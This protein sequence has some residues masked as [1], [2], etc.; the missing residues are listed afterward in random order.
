M[1]RAEVKGRVINDVVEIP[2]SA[3]R[4]DHT[5]L[6]LTDDEVLKILPVELA[7]TMKTKVLV[8]SGLADGM[9]V[10]VSPIEMPVDGM[11]L[12]VEEEQ[13]EDGAKTP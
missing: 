7:R 1:V 6:T 5:V 12:A 4:E 10:I 8:S 9:R 13:N 3:L 11:K 2:R